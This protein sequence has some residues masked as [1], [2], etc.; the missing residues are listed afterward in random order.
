MDLEPEQHR[1]ELRKNAIGLWSIVFFVVA[2]ASPLAAMLGTVPIVVGQGN[3]I[4][5]PAAWVMAGVILMLFSVGYGAMSRHISNAGAFYSYIA[6]GLGRPMGIGGAMIAIVSY[7]AVQL[8]LYGLFG[9]FM[10]LLVSEHLKID[11]AWW[12]YAVAA[13][14]AVY[15]C[16]RRKVDFSG[17]LLG[18]FMLGEV[19]V[20]L[21]LDLAVIARGGEEGLSL[22]SFAPHQVF[23]SGLG[24][25]LVFA[26]ASFIGFEATAIFAE[27]AR[28]A[29]RTVPM[30]TYLALTLITVFYTLSSWAAINGYGS[31]HVVEA[32]TKDSGNFW[33]VLNDRFVGKFST[34]LMQPLLITS[35]FAG[36]LSFHNTIT[37]YFFAMGREGLLWRSLSRTHRKHQS[38]HVAGIAQTAI[39]VAVIAIFAS[40][41]MDPY[42]IVFSWMSALATLGIL[43]NQFLVALSVIGF[44]RRTRLDT[45][46]WH[47][48]IS[49]ALAAAGLAVCFVLVWSNLGLLSGSDSLIVAA[50]PYI[51]LGVWVIGVWLGYYLRA[52]QPELYEGFGALIKSV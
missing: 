24:V 16:G 37:R 15:L 19:S 48:L 41:K 46:P 38:P 40:G 30:A 31:N 45:R 4:G 1:H 28:D 39:A 17:R 11:L 2:A 13:A 29:K 7:N 27:E 9:F 44:F 47:T 3:G 14:V 6:N 23:R 43:A 52:N 21:L 8:A 42:F 34:H 51:V 35:I 26:I 32:A 50:F 5:A 36:I 18:A 33:F 10:K 25:T 22:A 12:V 49:P 20:L